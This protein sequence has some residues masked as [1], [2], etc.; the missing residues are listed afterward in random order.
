MCINDIHVVNYD[1]TINYRIIFSKIHNLLTCRL[2]C[3]AGGGR[4]QWKTIHANS[5]DNSCDQSG[6]WYLSE[7][8]CADWLAMH[9]SVHAVGKN[10]S[11]KYMLWTLPHWDILGSGAKRN[12]YPCKEST[13]GNI[14]MRTWWIRCVVYQYRPVACSYL[15]DFYSF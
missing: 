11:G 10:F 8:L 1:Y 7:Y 13:H 4:R 12:W 9:W 15:Y 3:A 2:Q 14:G 6:G 5:R